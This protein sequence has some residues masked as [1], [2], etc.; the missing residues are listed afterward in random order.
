MENENICVSGRSIQRGQ[1]VVEMLVVMVVLMVPMFLSFDWMARVLQVPYLANDQ[2]H[3]AALSLLNGSIAGEWGEGE[4]VR[5]EAY[6]QEALRPGGWSGAWS[7]WVAQVMGN[8]GTFTRVEDTPFDG[9]TTVLV[10]G[11]AHKGIPGG[12]ALNAVSSAVGHLP[13]CDGL[14]IDFENGMKL[15][16]RTWYQV[17]SK[18]ETKS[19]F[20]IP[21][22][23]IERRA[24]VISNQWIPMNES[25]FQARVDGLVPDEI[26]GCVTAAGRVFSLLNYKGAPFGSLDT[27]KGYRVDA[28]VDSSILPN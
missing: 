15:P 2:S 27:R 25:A 10:E 8:R 21:D 13:F 6:P 5:D 4:V 7:K 17:R 18:A 23:Q 24:S 12:S 16:D 3:N 9:P 22:A 20:G 14:G 28:Q 26:I 11:L 1:A 19:R